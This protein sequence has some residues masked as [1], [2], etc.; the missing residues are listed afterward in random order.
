MY[1]GYDSVYC[2][3]APEGKNNMQ[4]QQQICNGGKHSQVPSHGEFKLKIDKI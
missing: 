4:Q 1:R 3:L 2:H